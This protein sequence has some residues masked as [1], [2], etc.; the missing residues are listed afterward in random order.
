M[1]LVSDPYSPAYPT[2]WLLF[3]MIFALAGAH[4]MSIPWPRL[5][6]VAFY[7]VALAWV[8][9]L[10]WRN[11]RHVWPVSALDVLFAGFALLVSASLIFRGD[12]LGEATGKFAAY[13]PFLVVIPYLC[14][15]LMK[16]QDI[17]LFM[18]IALMAGI[19]LLPVLLIDRFT[20]PG[21][22]FVRWPFF[23]Q[24]HGA[25]LAGTLLATALVALCVQALD[26]RNR[27][28]TNNRL[29]PL[30]LYGL[31]GLVTAFLVW[32][33]ARGWLLSAV[34]GVAAACLL[35]RQHSLRKRIALCGAV[36]VVAAVSL[37]V[38][39]ALDPQFGG[40]YSRALDVSSQPAWVEPASFVGAG[41]ILGEASCEPF[42]KG[43]NSIAMRWV[44]YK[45]AIAMFS[46]HPVF[47]V[48]PARFG[49]RSC[50][51]PMG[52]P[53][54]TILQGLAELGVIGGGLLIGLLTLA[55][56]TLVRPFLRVRQGEGWAAG[57]FVMALFAMFLVADQ[58]YGNYFM[59]ASMW[60]MLGIAASMH[61][62]AKRTHG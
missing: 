43:N 28:E 50:T 40:L 46:E 21:S 7:V 15:R 27:G 59:S 53:H 44:L 34:V 55:A 16:A 49:A 47:G 31:I 2:T 48:G 60:L 33:T 19:T 37:A 6:T 38:L 18:R 54:S 8:S 30:V 39:P 4:F 41:P 14:G 25:L 61:H 42:R 9:V 57:A 26:I 62:S 29:R 52:F 17:E 32:V 22:A 3:G 12:P 56:V 10:A 11:R 13:L 5:A 1:K 51:G 58:I 35:A 20:S 23:G 45:E 24:D 36:L